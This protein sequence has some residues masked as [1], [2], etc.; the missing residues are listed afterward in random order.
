MCH[1]MSLNQTSVKS[2]YNICKQLSL[3]LIGL[4]WFYCW[5]NW[6]GSVPLPCINYALLLQSNYLP[7]CLLTITDVCVQP[8]PILFVIHTQYQITGEHQGELAAPS[9]KSS[10]PN[11]S[12]APVMNKCLGR[13]WTR[14]TCLIK[15]SVHWG[16][17]SGSSM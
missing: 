9:S 3:T 13:N 4:P 5:C 17:N 16:E 14:Q 15:E 8:T 11:C 10:S 2:M 12:S 1:L 6:L 7:D